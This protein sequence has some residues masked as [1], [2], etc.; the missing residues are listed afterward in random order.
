M[1]GSH[2]GERGELTPIG[3]ARRLNIKMEVTSRTSYH[4][5]PFH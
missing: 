4:Q 2:C 1:D 3:G 5:H